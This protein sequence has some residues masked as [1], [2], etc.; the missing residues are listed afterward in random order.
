MSSDDFLP[1]ASLDQLKF[2]SEVLR[3][4]REFFYQRQYM[5]VE[6]PLLSHETIV[7]AHL[8]S[9]VITDNVSSSE[10]LY[11][12]TSPEAGM[13][14]LLAAG[15]RSIFQIT[16]SFRKGESG[17][18]HNPEFTI[19]EWY[20]AGDKPVEQMKFIEE[21]IQML[22]RKCSHK[23]DF[24]FLQPF[25]SMSYD[26]VFEKYFGMPV[27]NQKTE[28]IIKQ[29]IKRNIVFP[30]SFQSVPQADWDRDDILNFVL[31][32]L[33]EPELGR[34]A[35][36]FI[37]S[38]PPSQ[39]ALAKVTGTLVPI[40]ERF[41]LYCKGIELCNGYHELTDAD[42][43]EKRTKAENQKRIEHGY[44]ALP[45]PEKLIQAM[46]AGLSDCTG[47]AMGFDRLLMMLAG[48]SSLEEVI[49]FPF[50]RA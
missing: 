24:C 22:A 32:E 49:T 3:H 10:N 7:D 38:Y 42:E 4:L 18:L 36:L 33:I 39:A 30:E 44:P 28:F 21:M 41:E 45:A 5:E 12:Q 40:A 16:R 2:R 17:N 19:V 35:P 26:E 29:A 37:H 43:L 47:V 25:Q 48:K 27:L 50:S 1:T 8:N 11:L 31:S 14:R 46:R 9:F 20:Q 23:P 34:E 15:A 13:K 6:T